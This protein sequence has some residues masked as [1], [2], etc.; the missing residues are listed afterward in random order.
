MYLV[1]SE[2]QDSIDSY[3]REGL[4]IW[5]NNTRTKY[6]IRKWMGEVMVYLNDNIICMRDRLA[7]GYPLLPRSQEVRTLL[8]II[9]LAKVNGHT[10]KKLSAKESWKSPLSI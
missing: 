10:T 1:L 7:L 6:Q 9:S 5:D 4:Q 2:G 3:I 8:P